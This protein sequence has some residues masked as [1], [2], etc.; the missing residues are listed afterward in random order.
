MAI[1]DGLEAVSD[2]C[3]ATGLLYLKSNKRIL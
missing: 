2:L 1:P 3:K